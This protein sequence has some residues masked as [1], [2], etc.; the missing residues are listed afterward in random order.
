MWIEENYHIDESN[1][2]L[3][4]KPATQCPPAPVAEAPMPKSMIFVDSDEE[5]ADDSVRESDPES[6]GIASTSEAMIFIDSDDEYEE[7]LNYNDNNH[8]EDRFER[9]I[10]HYSR[11]SAIRRH[12]PQGKC[13]P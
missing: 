4:C 3:T 2:T 1:F 13:L 5:Y 6:R 8:N 10:I 11:Q 12:P 7:D 9:I